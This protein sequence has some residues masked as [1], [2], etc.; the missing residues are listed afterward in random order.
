MK[1]PG[2]GKLDLE[3][4]DKTVRQHRH[5]VFLSFPLPDQNLAASA[6]FWVD[7]AT[8]R[9]TAKCVRNASTSGASIA[10]G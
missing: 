1:G 6:W 9:S 3:W 10:R 2:A 5:A 8:L 4:L 7:A